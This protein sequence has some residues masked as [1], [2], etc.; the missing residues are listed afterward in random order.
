MHRYPECAGRVRPSAKIAVLGTLLALELAFAIPANAEK[1]EEVDVP[2]IVSQFRQICAELDKARAGLRAGV[3][4]DEE[5]ADRVLDLFVWADSLQ[6]DVPRAGWVQKDGRQAG[7]F[8]L[9]RALGYLIQSLRENYVG[10]ASKN[11]ADF[12]EADRAYQAAMAWR[13]DAAA[14]SLSAAPNTTPSLTATR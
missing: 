11:G 8:A 6:Q 13:P 3:L 9:S 2:A 10:I 4:G 12:V 7:T 5:F 1:P 14:P